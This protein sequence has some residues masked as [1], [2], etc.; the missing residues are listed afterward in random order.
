MINQ[1]PSNSRPAVHVKLGRYQIIAKV[2]QG[3]FGDVFEAS[4]PSLQRRVA[5]KTCRSQDFEIRRRFEHEATL[6]ASLDHRNLVATYDYAEQGDLAYLVQEFLEGEDLDQKIRREDDLSFATKLLYLIQLARGLAHAHRRG[7]LHR[8][9][10]PGNVRV[11]PDG[12]VKLMDFGIAK[13][14]DDDAH[15]TLAGETM[16]TASYLSPEQVRGE[17]LD[18]RCDIWG[19]GVTAYEVLGNRRAFLGEDADAIL[20]AVLHTEPPDILEIWPDCPPTMRDILQRCMA[21]DRSERYGDFEQVLSDFDQLL[22]EDAPQRQNPQSMESDDQ[23]TV[24]LQQGDEIQRPAPPPGLNSAGPTADPNQAGGP[25]LLTYVAGLVLMGLLGAGAAAWFFSRDADSTTDSPASASTDA[26]TTG[27]ETT[28][29]GT[30][31][32]AEAAEIEPGGAPRSGGSSATSTATPSATG[33]VTVPAAWDARMVVRVNGRSYSLDR[34]QSI[35]VPV[36]TASMD[37]SLPDDPETAWPDARRRGIQVRVTEGDTAAVEI[38]L[39]PPGA[40]TLRAALD[41][42]QAYIRLD[43]RALDWLPI[44]ALSLPPGGY[45]VTASQ[46]S[47]GEGETRTFALVIESGM[48]TVITL[49]LLSPDPPLT[50]TKE[51]VR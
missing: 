44:R 39:A 49:D 46:E 19:F 2:G 15:L 3:G 17:P 14:I 35:Q 11:L 27:P 12:Q 1:P 30:P 50:V 32:T 40:V 48:E 4:D 38:P 31:A 5:I 23:E 13:A 41:A 25:G 36:G 28:P 51:W 29:A 43:D 42:P 9:V 45:S 6:T 16:G 21:K 8:D 22:G 37:F 7:V 47:S 18:V 33:V 20:R 26:A 24:L 34:E 10:K